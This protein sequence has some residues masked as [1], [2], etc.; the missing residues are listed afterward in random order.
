MP[1]ELDLSPEDEEIL[2]AIWD[3]IAISGFDEPHDR[4]HG[5]TVPEAAGTC[6]PGERADLTGCAPAT[7]AAP[8]Q[9][10]KATKP[11]EPSAAG[12]PHKPSVTI[13]PTKERTFQGKP[14]NAA[15]ISK[16][17]AGKIGE[18]LIVAH[19]QSKGMKDARPMNLDRNNF[20]IDLVQDHEVIEVKTGQ[21]S[22]G[23]KAQQWRLT[24]GEP[25]KEEKAWLASAS[26]S[27]KE[28]WN[29]KKQQK[30]HERKQKIVKGLTKEMGKPPKV[31]TMTVILNPQTKTAALYKFDGL[32]D[33]VGW[34]SEQA[35]KGY[36]GSVKYASAGKR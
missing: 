5:K 25:G 9:K 2:D 32:H 10:G 34:N 16:Q 13:Q 1:V 3:R 19:L 33:R 29:A 15:K 8:K 30:I 22:N 27:D 4:R 11:S 21:V 18:D 31:S 6:K 7:G 17:E 28:A 14:V 20:P 12:Q 24:I 36:I 26:D 23:P 35:Q